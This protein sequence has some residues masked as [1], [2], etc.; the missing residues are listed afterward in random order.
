MQGVAAT[1]EARRPG[2]PVT[3]AG[4]IY[5]CGARARLPNTGGGV[6]SSGSGHAA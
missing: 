4:L 6:G 5:A 3:G 2:R 1:F